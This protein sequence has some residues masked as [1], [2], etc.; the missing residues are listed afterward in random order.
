MPFRSDS[1]SPEALRCLGINFGAIL[2]T[3]PGTERVITWSPPA[4][5]FPGGRTNTETIILSTPGTVF[6][7]RYNQV[8]INVRKNFRHGTKVFSVQFD[9]FNVPNGASILR[10]TTPSARPSAR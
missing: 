3:Y 2:Q 5:V 7:P 8:D 10:P 1:R 9:M 4:S 6:Q